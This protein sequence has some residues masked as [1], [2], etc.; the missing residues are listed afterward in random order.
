MGFGNW[1]RFWHDFWCGDQSLRMMYPILFEN[2]TNRD[3]LVES[4]LERLEEEGRR[5]W[6]VGFIRNFNYLEMEGV[7]SLLHL[8]EF[9]VPMREGGDQMLWK[10]NRSGDFSVHSFCEALWGSSPMSFP[11][12]A[13]WGLK[14]PELPSLCGQLLGGK[15]L[16]VKTLWVGVICAEV[17]ERR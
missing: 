7:A 10:L 14:I 3:A 16:L 1:I 4:L 8:L 9:H 5:Q 17:V 15:Y 2:A 12:K 11:W 13:I 6:Y